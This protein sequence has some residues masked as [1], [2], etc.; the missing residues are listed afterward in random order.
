MRNIKRGKDEED[1]GSKEGPRKE[2]KEERSRKDRERERSRNV[3]FLQ[4]RNLEGEI[5]PSMV[6]GAV[7]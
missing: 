4:R 2:E 3:R 1:K 5:P 7:I 6:E